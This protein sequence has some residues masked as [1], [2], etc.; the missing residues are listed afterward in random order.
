MFHTLQTRLAGAFLLVIS[1]IFA[2]TI[3]LLYI[4]NSFLESHNLAT[5][6]QL[7]IYEVSTYSSKL[8]ENYNKRIKVTE[9][10]TL[11]SEHYRIN[12]V[13][14]ADLAEIETKI[15]SNEG[16]AYFIGL[17]N[18]IKSIQMDCDNGIKAAEEGNP[19]TAFAIYDQVIRKNYYVEENT[20]NLVFVEINQTE[21]THKEL[22]LRTQQ[23]YVVGGIVLT[24]ILVVSIIFSLTFS[25]KISKPLSSL[26]TL[27][28][29]IS[30]G[31][32][33]FTVPK[34]LLKQTD[35]TGALANAFEQML[36]KIK[37]TLDTL[38]LSNEKLLAVQ[39]DI[40][41]KNRE[42]EK[43]NRVMVGRET[44]MI[45]LKKSASTLEKRVAELERRF[46]AVDKNPKG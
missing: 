43:F 7:K 16:K 41:R 15:S 35:E 20:S 46:P 8:I 40:E 13:I 32:F 30:H 44:R 6:A 14:N 36:L 9:D 28:K 18:L 39:R 22:I 33:E 25:R 11:E 37:A 19:V 12:D 24:L 3:V 5:S 38:K 23:S 42:L 10:K 2:I 45:D 34:S 4:Q 21:Q 29:E 17:K 1:V 26:T 27:A 31:N